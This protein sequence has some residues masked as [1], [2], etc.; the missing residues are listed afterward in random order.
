M[1][2]KALYKRVVISD[3][4]LGIKDSKVNE[5]ISFL[6]QHPCKELIMN[7]DIIDGWRLQ[8]RGK[9]RHRHTGFLKYLIK[10]SE[11][12]RIVYVR[13]NH[14]D[15]LDQMVPIGFGSFKIVSHYSLTS[16]GKKYYV[17]HGDVFDNI[18]RSVV[19][20]S[21]FGASS[22]DILLAINRIYNRWR[23]K[24]GLKYRSVSK[25][26][27]N[28]V[29]F[30]TSLISN[31]EYKAA[32]L[33]RNYG[34]DG[35]ICGH[36]HTPENKFIHGIHYMNSGDWVEGMSALVEDFDGNWQIKYF[37]E[38]AQEVNHPKDIHIPAYANPPAS[39][40]RMIKL[41]EKRRK[42]LFEEEN[43]SSEKFMSTDKE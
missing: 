36:I 34:Y 2:Q 32:L 40:N 20:I 35:I 1:K 24:R 22:Y 39:E 7:G 16:K 9:W 3:L 13:G 41:Q 43:V 19:W 11:Q 18:T 37:Q 4:H 15:F 12:T 33:A 29:K 27:K 38:M 28:K 26:I 6:K 21:K 8:K 17:I 42:L 30:V 31:F 25:L 5:V 23:Y 10:I 14:D